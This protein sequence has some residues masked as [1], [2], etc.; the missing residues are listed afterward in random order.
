MDF[1]ICDFGLARVSDPEH[2]HTGFLTEYV[3]TRYANLGF[4]NQS[5][6]YFHHFPMVSCP[7]DHAQLQGLHQIHRCLVRGLHPGGNAQQPAPLPRKTLSGP[8]EPDTR[9]CRLAVPRGLA[10]H[11]Q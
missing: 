3:A 7:G 1:Q 5:T 6:S 2:D 4:R 9:G 8:A 10:M 11:C